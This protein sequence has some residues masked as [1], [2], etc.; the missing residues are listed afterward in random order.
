MLNQED[1]RIKNFKDLPRKGGYGVL[2]KGSNR[3][4]E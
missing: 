3:E 2:S 4:N 1:D